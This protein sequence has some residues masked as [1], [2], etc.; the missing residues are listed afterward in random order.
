MMPNHSR[1]ILLAAALL[2][3]ASAPALAQKGKPSQA[4]ANKKLYCWDQNGQRVCSDTLPQDAVNRARDEFNAKSGLR[5]AEVDR[6]LTV[7]ERASLAAE[8]AQSRLDDAA[9]QTRKR[10]DQAMLM[11]YQSE[12]DL[13]R[14]FTER[15][16]ILDNNVATARYNVASLRDGLVTL[17]R[18]AG[19]RELGG[20]KVPE[21]LATEI[22]QRHNELLW[23]QRLQVSFEKQRADLDGEVSDTLRR[24]RDLKGSP[25]TPPAG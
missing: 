24:Y 12:D 20:Q 1:R 18:T 4:A 25:A 2:A 6:A 5:S 17:L 8:A 3:A 22:R 10:T 16:A 21:K 14:V 19:E 11:S 9:E 13:R 23:Q 7:E 15:T